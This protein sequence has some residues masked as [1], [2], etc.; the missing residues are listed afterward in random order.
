MRMYRQ[1]IFLNQCFSVR[2]VL[3]KD[4]HFFANR[5]R[6]G[7]LSQRSNRE[8]KSLLFKMLNF[9]L[10]VFCFFS[11]PVCNIHTLVIADCLTEV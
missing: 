3:G 8:I 5:I 10:C 11:M 9:R 1:V 7:Q 4:S 6:F 2:D